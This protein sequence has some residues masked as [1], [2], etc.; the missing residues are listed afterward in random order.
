MS[1]RS[2]ILIAGL[3][4]T[5]VLFVFVALR[6]ADPGWAEGGIPLVV[7]ALPW[8]IPVLLIGGTVSMIPGIGRVLATEA[9]TSSCLS[10]FVGASTGY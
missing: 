6:Y 2:R 5:F 9:G 1:S 3:Y 8:S 7:V 4:W 10:F